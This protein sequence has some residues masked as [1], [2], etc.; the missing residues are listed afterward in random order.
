MKQILL[1]IFFL[2]ALFSQGR[3]QSSTVLDSYIKLG[4]ENNHALKQKELNLEKSLETLKEANGLFYPSIGFSSQY[5][6][7]NGGR[8]TNLP[9][10][11]LLNPVYSSLNDLTAQPG[12]FP[13]IKNE[14]IKFLPNDYHDTKLRVILPLVNTEIYYNRKIKNELI[15]FSKAELNVY[16]RELIKEIKTAYLR[17]L[18]SVKVM[19]AYTSATDLIKEALYVNEKLVKNQM[20]VNDKVL[21]FRAELSQVEAQL[22][23]AVC[24]KKAASAY[25][26]FLVNSPLQTELIIDSALFYAHTDFF[27]EL[28]VQNTREEIDQLKSSE[29][30]A[31]YNL[32]MRK[33]YWIPTLSN[34]TDLG[35]QGYQFKFNDDQRYIMN[36]IEFKWNIFDGFQNRRR[37]S[38]ARIEKNTLES[39]LSETELQIKL[40]Q[41][42]A[43]DNY[44]SA[45]AAEK[46]NQSSLVSSREY[47]KI[48]SRQYSEGQKSM[49]DL[50]DARNQLTNS[51]I[52]YAVSHF[53]SLIRMAEL[54]R[55]LAAYPL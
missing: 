51:D 19:E 41:Q 35:Y 34:V 49:L 13:Q 15:G 31:W 4:L 18:Q 1:L 17:F 24:D 2:T 50:L 30:A 39:K 45:I 28:P 55:A 43:Q 3:G 53:E 23:K 21:R 10:G 7:S 52:N 5:T 9:I 46:A 33:S 16:K 26:N 20:A 37:L 29:K 27:S 42:V 54:E 48:V 32:N 12:A 38:Q 36:V 8:S 25:F 11:D 6:L 22:T 44:K 40:Q 47:Y 14:E